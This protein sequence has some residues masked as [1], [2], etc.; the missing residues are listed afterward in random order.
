MKIVAIAA[1]IGLASVAGCGGAP[2]ATGPIPARS[3]PHRLLPSPARWK[4]TVL[5]S[6]NYTDGAYNL[7][8]RLLFDAAGN[9]YGTTQ[10]GGAYGC[11]TLESCGSPSS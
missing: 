3:V 4:E 5:H 9:L 6:F 1:S 11:N 8:A 7:D 10:S 2:V